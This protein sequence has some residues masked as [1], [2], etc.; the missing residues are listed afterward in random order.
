MKIRVELIQA[1]HNI[2]LSKEEISAKFSFFIPNWEQK[3][4][5][6]KLLHTLW[7][8]NSIGMFPKVIYPH[9]FYEIEGDF[10]KEDLQ[11]IQLNFLAD[12]AQ[13]LRNSNIL[14]GTNK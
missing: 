13:E 7:L 8:S 10:S 6:S 4:K 2:E 1:A 3:F 14:A 9:C 11:K 5:T 12:D